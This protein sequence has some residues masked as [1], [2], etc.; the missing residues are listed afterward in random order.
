MN[1][2][3]SGFTCMVTGH[4]D[5]VKMP[6][7]DNLYCKYSFNYGHDWNVVHGVEHGIS[8]IARRGSGQDSQV[9]IWNYPVDITFRSSNVFGWPQIVISVYG[10]N[11]MGKDV[12]KGYGC[13]HLPVVPGS[14]TVYVRLYVPASSSWCN[15]LT[16]WITGNPPEFFD[17]KF[18]SQGKG[19][20]VT[21]VHSNGVVKLTLNVSTRNMNKW[22]FKTQPQ[23]L[24]RNILPQPLKN[25]KNKTKCVTD[26]DD[27]S[28]EEEGAL[29]LL[30]P[31]ADTGEGVH[32]RTKKKKSK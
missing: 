16:S 28:E 18:V 26:S 9:F 8:Q 25:K 13:I 22:G 20:E 3:D 5:A 27:E 1:T 19:R 7:V 21:R 12:I 11:F 30:T 23:A 32:K 31:A 4:I 10:I 29:D 6:G 14:H 24:E 2:Q 17:A 15:R